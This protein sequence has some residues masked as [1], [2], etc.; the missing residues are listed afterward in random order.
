MSPRTTHKCASAHFYTPKS[1]PNFEVFDNIVNCCESV[2]TAIFGIIGL[3]VTRAIH[4]NLQ[5]NFK[6]WSK[7]SEKKKK[8]KQ[9]DCIKTFQF[10]SLTKQMC[11]CSLQ[12]CMPKYRAFPFIIHVAVSVSVSVLDLHGL[13]F[14]VISSGDKNNM[15]ELENLSHFPAKN[16]IDQIS[17]SNLEDQNKIGKIY[18]TKDCG[19]C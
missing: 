9:G 1:F 10:I 4:Y 2:E 19:L 16:G 18:Q 12:F 11:V 7:Y 14:K 15:H 6:H 5:Q 17:N 8:E 13:K 3:F